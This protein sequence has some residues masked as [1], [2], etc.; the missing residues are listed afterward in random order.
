[1]IC[2]KLKC[3]HCENVFKG[4]YLPSHRIELFFDEQSKLKDKK[5][6]ML[7]LVAGTQLGLSNIW[8][9]SKK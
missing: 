2:K 9:F 8:H 6:Q 1:M 3:A 7:T 5:Q 4:F